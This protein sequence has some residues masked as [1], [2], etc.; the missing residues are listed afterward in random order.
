MMMNFNV[1]SLFTK[2]PVYVEKSVIFVLLSK[3]GCLQDRTTVN[4][5]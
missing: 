3:D 2:I 1:V 4:Y 5:V